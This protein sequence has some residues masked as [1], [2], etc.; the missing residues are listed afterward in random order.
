VPHRILIAYFPKLRVYGFWFGE[1]RFAELLKTLEKD[2]ATGL[3]GWPGALGIV[4]IGPA[5]RPAALA[6][7]RRG[8][9]FLVGL[10]GSVLIEP[11]FEHADGTAEVVAQGEGQVDVV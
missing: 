11:A 10:P 4:E 7:G 6:G 5:R 3:G 9:R 8:R 2:G 1:G